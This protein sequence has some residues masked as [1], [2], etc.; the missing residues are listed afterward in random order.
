[1]LKLLHFIIRFCRLRVIS[2]LGNEYLRRYTYRSL[3]WFPGD[4]PTPFSIYLHHFIRPDDD[5]ELHSHPWKW[6]VSVTLAGG[7][8]EE[9]FPTEC[10]TCGHPQDGYHKVTRRTRFLSVNFIRGTDYHRVASLHGK[11]TWT[12]FIAGPKA[13]SW[14]FWV[15]GRGH[16]EWRTFLTEK[17]MKVD[18]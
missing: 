2:T 18:Y 5:R 1:M 8:V 12:L 11:E 13:S 15:P 9:R 4:K 6:A 7:Y 3:G 16:V 10:D 17:G 14:G